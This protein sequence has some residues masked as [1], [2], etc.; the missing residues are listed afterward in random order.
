MSTN[1]LDRLIS[2]FTSPNALA[3][4][5]TWLPVLFFNTCGVVLA[6]IGWNRHRVFGFL[7]F[8][9]SSALGIARSGLAALAAS[10]LQHSHTQ[11]MHLYSASTTLGYVAIIISLWGLGW[12][13]FR[14]NFAR[15]RKPEVYQP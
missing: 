6:A 13:V 3:N 2:Y 10:Q 9:I 5:A 12:F 1:F 11:A 8:L 15:P 14:A 4:L 7:L